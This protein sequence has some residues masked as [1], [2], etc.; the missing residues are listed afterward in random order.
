ME[1]HYELSVHLVELTE[2]GENGFS[3]DFSTLEEAKQAGELL[4]SDKVSE[5]WVLFIP[6][7]QRARSVYHKRLRDN[8]GL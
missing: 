1:G 4:E 6:P 5:W 8:E 7:Y 3:E 2:D